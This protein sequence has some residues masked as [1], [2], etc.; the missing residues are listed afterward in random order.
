M[1]EEDIPQLAALINKLTWYEKHMDIY[2]TTEERYRRYGFCEDAIFKAL[3]T[4]EL[5]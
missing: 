3:R 2:T 5:Q 1:T 4:R